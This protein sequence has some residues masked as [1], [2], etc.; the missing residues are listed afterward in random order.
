MPRRAPTH[1]LPPQYAPFEDDGDD[2]LSQIC[3]LQIFFSLLSSIILKTNPNSPAMGVILPILIGVPPL[4]AFIFESGVL[5]ELK[6]LSKSEDNG[7]PIPFTGGK[8]VGVGCRAK[9][10]RCLERLLGVKHTIVEDEDMVDDVFGANESST[11]DEGKDV[12]AAMKI[13]KHIVETFQHFD[14]DSSGHLDYKEL[15]AALKHYGIDVSHPGA[16]DIIK[17]YD[18]RPDGRMQLSEFAEL[19]HNVMYGMIRTSWAGREPAPGL[20]VK[21]DQPSRAVAEDKAEGSALGLEGFGMR[22][23]GL[24]S[25]SDMSARSA[26]AAPAAAA[27]RTDDLNV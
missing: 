13:P 26:S 18:T 20:R 23:K 19:A 24:M 8:R 10:T 1:P 3:Q 17:R 7:W 14:V 12:V 27:A 4:S 21:E 5:D 15:R 6:K 25:P 9:A 11:S 22:L 2:L 16:A